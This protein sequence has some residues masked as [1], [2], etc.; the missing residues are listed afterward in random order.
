MLTVVTW[1]VFY[2]KKRPPEE[3]EKERGIDERR[4][5]QTNG[6]MVARQED[7]YLGIGRDVF[8][9]VKDGRWYS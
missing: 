3:M 8:I 6:I 9:H 1:Y 4:E 5:C 2:E 7:R